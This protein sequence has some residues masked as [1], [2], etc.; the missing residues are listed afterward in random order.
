[1]ARAADEVQAIDWAAVA[2]PVVLACTAVVVLL[3]DVVVSPRRSGVRSL[4]PASLTL[5]GVAAA[6]AF[7]VPLWGG[8]RATFC[9]SGPP[10]GG[11]SPC[12]FVVDQLTL[13]FWVVV[14]FGTAVVALLGTAATVEGRTPPGEWN[15]LLLCSATGALVI[16]G[17]RDLVTL[18]VALEVVSSLPSPWWACAGGTL[19]P[20]RRRSSSSWSR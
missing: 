6:A 7:A 11:P 2:S 5:A 18:V 12:S 16:A 19:E 3:A 20:P 8:T 14:L 17:S 13:G 4:L 9:V 10:L 1:V 15:F